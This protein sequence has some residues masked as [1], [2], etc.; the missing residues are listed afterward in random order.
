MRNEK[1]RNDKK[2]RREIKALRCGRAYI[3]CR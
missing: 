3:N 2:L 1:D